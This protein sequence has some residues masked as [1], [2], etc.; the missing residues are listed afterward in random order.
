[1]AIASIGTR[2]TAVSGASTTT[3]ARAPTA[4][5]AVG[6]V[7]VAHFA[8]RQNIAISTVTDAA[9]N[10][11]QFIGRYSHSGTGDAHNEV[12]LCN[13]TTQLTTGTNITATFGSAIVDKCMALW[14]YS[15][16]SGNV[17][18]VV[19]P[20]VGNQV[21]AA[22][23]FG[24]AAFAGLASAQ[25][26]YFRSGSKRANSTGTITATSGYTTHALNIRSR[27]S[28]TLAITLRAEHLIA[29][30]TG[31]TSN[32]T[33]AVSGN[34]AANFV[35]FE[36]YSPPAA[37]TLTQNTRFDNGQTFYNPTV[38][39]GAVSLT[40]PLYTN[41]QVFY[42]HEVTASGGPQSLTVPLYTNNNTFYARSVTS[43][44]SV[45]AARYDNANAFYAP[46]VAAVYTLTAAR[47][48]NVNTFYSATV[49]NAGNILFP[50]YYTNNNTFYNATLAANNSLTVNRYDNSNAFYNINVVQNITFLDWVEPGHVEDGWVS[51][52]YFNAPTF[53]EATLTPGALGITVP[54]LLNTNVFYDVAVDGGEALLFP[55][56]V[57]NNNVFYTAAVINQ[58][59]DPRYV[60]KGIVY[61]PGLVGEY[62]DGIKV[63]LTTGQLVKPL[64]SKV[65]IFL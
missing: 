5:V 6:R 34:T 63:E 4:T 48:D 36:E 26:L 28:S 9:G 65:A 12:W 40:V 56:L 30:N 11:W 54:L 15:V 16:G 57:T 42:T 50:P 18:Q 47:F 60:L 39:V 24:S 23:G 64:N 61:G 59:P 8:A 58:Y 10:T 37:Q 25:R 20:V 62:Q 22:N 46:S 2:G 38:T 29:T 33:W 31:T 52:P 1:M 49:V 13:V 55:E 43:S 19:E 14:E 3:I 17:L 7:L 32:P 35:A 45:T 51:W 41:T 53:F 27:N 21:N 44:Y